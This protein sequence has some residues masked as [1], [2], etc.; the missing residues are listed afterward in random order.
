MTD[1][2]YYTPEIEEFH[3]GFE[4][5]L[6]HPIFIKKSVLHD[7]WKQRQYFGE[8]NLGTFYDIFYNTEKSL[9]VE[10][11]NF[12]QPKE[13]GWELIDKK[14][15]F[16]T[17]EYLHY[18]LYF[19]KYGDNFGIIS[20]DAISPIGKIQLFRGQLKNKSEFKKLLNQLEIK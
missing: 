12:T 11:F 16:W 15:H 14:E 4:F 5:E 9:R 13:F 20:I 17:Y 3:F 8:L 6:N 18:R 2:K 10:K 1:N 7:D 19:S